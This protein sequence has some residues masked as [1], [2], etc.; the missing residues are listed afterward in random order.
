MSSFA[1]P[2]RTRSIAWPIFALVI[3][4]VVVATLVIF[5]VT[6]NGPPP[7]MASGAASTVAQMLRTG[8]APPNVESR[9]AFDRQADV[10][11]PGGRFHPDPAAARGLAAE[12]GV[13][14]S[15]V[16]AF[17]MRPLDLE[18]SPFGRDFVLAWRTNG[19][20]RVVETPS[21]F[22][23]PWHMKTLAAML[24][25][26]M[27][28][29]V[30]AWALARAISRPLA[31]VARA[32]EQARAG[33]TLP[34]LPSGGAR[35]VRVLSG[36]VAA[37]HARLAAHAAG[38]TTM[39]AAIAHDM[40]TPLSR[41]SFRV[42]QL[43]EASRDRAAADLAE[44]RA[45]IAAALAFARDET[46]DI[47]PRLDLGSLIESLID[48]MA[49]AGAPVTIV[50]GRRAVIR[51]D[52]PALRRLFTNLLENAIRYGEQ[53]TIGWHVTWGNV[54]VTVDDH[55]PGIDPAT[56]ERLF[57]PFV[58]GDPSRNRATGGTGL[59]LAIVRSIA[60]RHGGEAVLEN[61]P[62]GARARVTL[63]LA[64]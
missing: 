41:L 54:E 53:A 19:E 45:M 7:R 2:L 28:L 5:I 23:A 62:T 43:P 32:A 6:F 11:S 24:I 18:R 51:G 26:I 64:G 61:G 52:S 20:W 49:D 47:T 55:G 37:M 25:A 39:L 60:N 17:T 21:P 9:L 38:R 31:E 48:D 50:A 63:P 10:P 22:L 16:A 29:A 13:P 15:D 46:S 4:S 8:A 36:A 34:T 30:P 33:T 1:D 58:R 35:E 14:V 44:M 3:V 42:E 57:E 40:G 27:A 59:G 56:V 12:L